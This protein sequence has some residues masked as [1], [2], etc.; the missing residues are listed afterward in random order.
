MKKIFLL[1]AAFLLIAF[2]ISRVVVTAQ[3]K[4]IEEIEKVVKVEEAKTQNIN[5]TREFSA[6]VKG[7]GEVGI[8]PEISG[9]LMQ[10]NKKEGENIF[11]GEILATI[12]ANDFFALNALSKEQIKVSE[13]ALSSADEYQDQLVDEARIEL[14]KAEDAKKEAK[15]GS[16]ESAIKLAKRNV[17]KAEEAVRTAKRMRDLQAS[18]T[19][20]Q[21][22]ISQKQANITALNINKTRIRAPFNGIFTK[23]LLQ[24]GEIV[25]PQTAIFVLVQSK[26]K[27]ITID[28]PAEVAQKMSIGQEVSV[29]RGDE[30]K[31]QFIAKVDSISPVS[32]SVTRK[33]SAKFVFDNEDVILGEFI[34]VLIPV[35]ESKES[36]AIPI[37]SIKKSYFENI[38]FI[39]EDGKAK[40]QRVETGI[41]DGNLIEIQKG[42]KEGEIF[43]TDG[44]QNLRNGDKIRIYE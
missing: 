34:T 1:I 20:G 16:D 30:G 38:I 29:I 25:S 32:D 12:D 23:K 24:E 2:V 33:S 44:Q 5:E 4:N 18:L 26:E 9:R 28:L 14:E 27:E 17:D 15:K 11:K 35:S 21:V 31:D 10:I 43:V 6:I 42:L 8:A 37:T 40:E 39:I 19:Q 3:E 41:I 7:V 13:D 36:I 22:D